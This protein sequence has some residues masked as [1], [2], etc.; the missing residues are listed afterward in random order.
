MSQGAG[1]AANGQLVKGLGSGSRQWTSTFTLTD[2]DGATA[3]FSVDLATGNVYSAGTFTTAGVVD[4]G[5]NASITGT[6]EVGGAT[7]LDST[8]AVTGATTLAA[9]S[10]TTGGFSGLVTSTVAAGS[11]VLKFTATSDTPTVEWTDDGTA[12][13][14]PTTAP[15]GYME[16][17]DGSNNVRYIP[18]W[19]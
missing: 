15:S 6:L 1:N 9:V 13:H 4:G 14:A 2:V 18:F 12:A 17:R 16:I 10:A 5:G 3:L 19:A 7:T 8:L 11:P